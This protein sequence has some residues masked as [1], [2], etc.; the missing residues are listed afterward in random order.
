MPT[1]H[2]LR[3]V[4]AGAGIAGLATALRLHRDG[5][6]VLVAERAPA[7]R[8]GGYLVNLLG[9]GFDAAERLGMV[10]ALLERDQGIFTS[11]LVRADGSTRLTMPAALAEQSLGS[12]AL[13]VFR[14]D[15]EEAL[16]SAI[17]GTVEVRFGTTITAIDDID[18][19]LRVTFSDGT[20][21]GA[22]LLV[23]ADGL[24]SG[25]R[26]LAFGP[27]QEYV[28]DLRHAVAAF[29]L[30]EAPRGLPEQTASTFIDVGRTAA[31][32]H[33]R[34]HA[35]SAFFTYRTGDAGPATSPATAVAAH[36]GDLTGPVHEAA[37]RA[38]GT[39]DAYFDSVSQVVMDGWRRGRVVLVGD[40]AWCVSLF[41]GHGAGLALAGADRL[42]R[43]IVEHPENVEAA[44]DA[45]EAALR[46]EI[47]QRQRQA[48][49]G[50]AR[51][52]PPSRLHLGVQDLM[53]R[54]LTTPLL[55]PALLHLMSRAR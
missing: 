10:P 15:L 12:R 54:A 23:G 31:V 25:V 18:G 29:P 50:M 45:W 2:P 22:D 34:S 6:R 3:I 28:R 11:L 38:A 43:A 17:D 19:P 49:A 37:R 30:G 48:R 39:Q 41:A 32:F 35:P 16:W 8:T 42:G 24:H 44:L 46:P 20:V 14:G 47:T 4:I 33:P 52:A 13:T 40:A 5:H 55:G 7:R 21:H 26:E 53:I 9:P 51:F 1:E 36:F 27:E